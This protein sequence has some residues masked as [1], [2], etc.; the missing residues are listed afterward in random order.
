MAN[1]YVLEKRISNLKTTTSWKNA[2]ADPKP[3]R[4]GKTHQ[5][6]QDHYVLEKRISNSK[7]TTS[8]KMRSIYPGS[9]L[10][11][12]DLTDLGAWEETLESSGY[13]FASRT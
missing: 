9:S 2:S 13:A 4:P 3:L 12:Y 7:T 5:Q 11:L 6:P 8:W 1:H 10:S